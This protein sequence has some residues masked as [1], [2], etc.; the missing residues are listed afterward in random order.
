MSSVRRG[1]RGRRRIL[2]DLR[3][4]EGGERGVERTSAYNERSC[5]EARQLETWGQV[6]FVVGIVLAAIVFLGSMAGGCAAAEESYRSAQAGIM[7]GAFFGGALGGA[8]CVLG[9]FLFRL[10]LRAFAIITEAHYR[11]LRDR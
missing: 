8:G 5:A 1:K 11:K 6:V 3:Q 4:P 10:V 2:R 9:G 7:I